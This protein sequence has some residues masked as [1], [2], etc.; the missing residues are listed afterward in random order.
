MLFTINYLQVNM[1]VF[2]Q[3][4]ERITGQFLPLEFLINY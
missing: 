3:L 1:A 2:G 4:F